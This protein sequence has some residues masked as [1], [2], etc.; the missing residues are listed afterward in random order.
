MHHSICDQQIC[1]NLFT[2]NYH[3]T[4]LHGSAIFTSAPLGNSQTHDN[5]NFI[6]FF[7]QSNHLRKDNL[8]YAPLS[9]GFENDCMK[10]IKLISGVSA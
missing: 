10:F 5:L 7:S 9:V 4:Y 2:F 1:E 8:P 6:C 3:L